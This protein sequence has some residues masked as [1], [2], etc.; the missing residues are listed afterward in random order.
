ML[1][2]DIIMGF[3]FKILACLV[4]N[5]NFFSAVIVDY[6]DFDASETVMNTNLFA[7]KESVRGVLFDFILS[8]YTIKYHCMNTCI[9]ECSA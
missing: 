3:D 9:T 1:H 4:L 7:N 8:F 6:T 5:C 2:K